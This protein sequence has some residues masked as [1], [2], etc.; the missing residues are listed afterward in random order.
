MALLPFEDI[1]DFFDTE[2]FAVLASYTPGGGSPSSIKVIFPIDE[3]FIVE[4]IDPRYQD[5][6]I[7]E[8][9]ALAITVDVSAAKHKDDITIDGTD[10][11]IKRAKDMDG[12]MT[13]L[14]LYR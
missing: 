2:E 11:K 12:G 1:D 10:Y 9:M 7:P 5:D 3:E 6:E 4:S 13:V 8:L 14:S